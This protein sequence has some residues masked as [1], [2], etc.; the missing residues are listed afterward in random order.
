[1][2]IYLNV[3]EIASEEERE[4]AKACGAKWDK[5]KYKFYVDDAD[6][7]PAVSKWML[8]DDEN[9][10][11]V[12]KDMLFIVEGVYVCRNCQRPIEVICFLMK[13]EYIFTRREDGEIECK[14]GETPVIRPAFYP[15]PEGLEKLVERE[16]NFR[17][18]Y[19]YDEDY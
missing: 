8:G 13:D 6:E 16:Y 14:K 11:S 12:V 5:T 3:P 15:M 10:C 4:E 18:P 7:C 1:M 9:K 17:V 19:D 2:H